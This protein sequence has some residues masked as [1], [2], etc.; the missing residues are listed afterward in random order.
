MSVGAVGYDFDYGSGRICVRE[1][2]STKRRY[3]LFGSQVKPAFQ[4]RSLSK[5]LETFGMF[6]EDYG[7]EDMSTN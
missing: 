3:K 5:L 4:L 7:S 1:I 6:W 2:D